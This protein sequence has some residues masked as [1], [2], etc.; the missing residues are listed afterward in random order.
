MTTTRALL[1]RGAG[2]EDE[3]VSLVSPTSIPAERSPVRGSALADLNLEAASQYLAGRGLA[4]DTDDAMLTSL[5]RAGLVAQSGSQYT[6]TS[7][8]LLCFG[9]LPQF[10]QPHW[11]VSCVQIDGSS[12]ADSI[13]QQATLA[14]ALPQLLDGALAFIAGAAPDAYPA[15]AVREAI[16]NALV[17]RELRHTAR[18]AVQIFSDRLII[19]SPGGLPQGVPPLAQ[20]ASGGGESIPRNPLLATTARSLGLGDQ[21]GRGLALIRAATQE[22][23]PTRIVTSPSEV[24]LILP[25]PLAH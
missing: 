8:G 9:P 6:P 2:C 23:G 22:R 20:M 13:V 4:V 16:V 14:G 12:M 15:D 7:V 24:R 25:A 18:V 19:R 21:I 5:V 17:H 1:A 3:A 10:L 11:G